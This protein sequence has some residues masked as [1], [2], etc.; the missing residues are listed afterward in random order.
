MRL[1][2][3]EDLPPQRVDGADIDR[4]MAGETLQHLLCR[5]PVV[6]ESGDRHRLEPTI[7]D[8][9]PQA[10][11]QD[12]GLARTGRC[13]H[14]G[15]ADVVSH[16]TELIGC[17]VERGGS[18]RRHRG[19]APQL[20][21]LVMDHDPVDVEGLSRTSV[22]PGRGAV[23]A[24]DVRLP[25]DDDPDPGCRLV[26]PPPHRWVAAGVV[27]VVP[28]RL[29]QAFPEKGEP[30]TQFV[31]MEIGGLGRAQLVLGDVELVHRWPSADVPALGIFDHRGEPVGVGQEQGVDADSIRLGPTLGGSCARADHHRPTKL[32][33]AARRHPSQHTAGE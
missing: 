10:G 24:D 31:G 28:D 18:R 27:R 32:D 19:H 11:H 3:P 12:P 26:T 8:E 6:G 2:R 20:H 21:R 7:L 25:A 16:G 29:H 5:S 1:G 22:D 15:R 33:W 30:G 4:L 17:E 13:D 9:V 23:G 14:P